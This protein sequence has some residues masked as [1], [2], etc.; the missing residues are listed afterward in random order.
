MLKLLGLFEVGRTPDGRR[1]EIPRSL[2]P[3]AAG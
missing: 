1:I 3:V 2:L